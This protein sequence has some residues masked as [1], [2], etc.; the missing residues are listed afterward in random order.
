[1]NTHQNQNANVPAVI[2]GF[3]DTDPTASPL[4]GTA[5][6]FKDGAYETFGDTVDVKESSYVVIDRVQG[7]QKLERDCPPE[8]LVRKTGEPKPAQPV[9]PKDAWPLDLNGKPSHPWKW[10]N[11]IYLLDT[12]TGEFSTFWSNTIGGNIAV[13]ELSD[14]VSLMRN[15]R[16]G[17]IPVVALC[18]KD[19]PTQFGGTKPRPYFKIL[20]W[21]AHG[22]DQ[23]LLASPEL[24][25]IEA[26]K[27]AEELND[28][29][30]F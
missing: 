27:L 8:Y 18:A 21:K 17:A 23:A 10:T 4:R 15:V 1:V 7:W 14:Q 13:G 5:L 29:I 3:A 24:R 6:R 16:P 19:M 28:S 9:V 25:E 30:G 26:P 12:A 2:D 20:G 11:Y 22:S